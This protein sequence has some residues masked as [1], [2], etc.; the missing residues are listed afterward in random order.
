MKDIL[1]VEDGVG[2]FPEGH[3]VDGKLIRLYRTIE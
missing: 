2:C 3:E 1:L